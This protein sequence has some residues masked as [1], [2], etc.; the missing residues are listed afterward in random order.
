MKNEVC[1]YLPPLERI[2]LSHYIRY[3][4][5]TTYWALLIRREW[6]N[7]ER[8]LCCDLYR[9]LSDRRLRLNSTSSV[10]G[11][12]NESGD[13]DLNAVLTTALARLACF[14]NGGL[15][16]FGNFCEN[17]Q[18]MA[19]Y[20]DI[21]GKSKPFILIPHLICYSVVFLILISNLIWYRND[22][23]TARISCTLNQGPGRRLIPLEC[24][25]QPHH[26]RIITYILAIYKK[27]NH[28]HLL[29]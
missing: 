6:N 22:G 25:L 23:A 15:G 27:G 29:L 17:Q 24:N 28:Y 8:S 19:K 16:G 10:E 21:N 14:V 4:E 1:V 11:W 3:R 20:V 12:N 5:G 18:E 9:S 26:Y 13:F 7:R 2:P